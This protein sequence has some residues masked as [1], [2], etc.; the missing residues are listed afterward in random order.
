MPWI[1]EESVEGFLKSFC[2]GEIVVAAVG[3]PLRG[4]DAAALGVCGLLRRVRCITCPYGLENCIGELMR[5]RG[6]RL[7]VVDAL[8]IP[9]A[10]PASIAA[11]YIDEASDNAMVTSHSVPAKRIVEMLRSTGAVAEAAV[12][13]IVPSSLALGE[14]PSPRVVEAYRRLAEIIERVCA[15]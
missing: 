13:G 7:L 8:L 10:S 11:A 5:L 1:G 12:A 14:K 3:S 2:R 9:G 6:A 15:P 4:D